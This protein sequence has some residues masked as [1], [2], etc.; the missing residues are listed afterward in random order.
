MVVSKQ[1]STRDPVIVNATDAITGRIINVGGQPLVRLIPSEN[2]GSFKVL[3]IDRV[4]P[5][6]F[7]CEC[8]WFG[9]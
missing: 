2:F 5:G 6:M 8:V 3:Y 9:L 7:G 1:P 4:V